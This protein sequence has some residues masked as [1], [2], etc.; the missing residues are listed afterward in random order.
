MLSSDILK[1]NFKVN[2]GVSSKYT[3]TVQRLIEIK[4]VGLLNKR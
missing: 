2:K 4:T 1:V 3:K